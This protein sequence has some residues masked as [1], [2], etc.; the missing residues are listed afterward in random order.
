M[1][2]KTCKQC[3][4]ELSQGDRFCVRCGA[5]VM[6]PADKAEG[7]EATRRGS[8]KHFSTKT[9]I[10]SILVI[11]IATGGFWGWKSYGN[12]EARTQKQLELAVKYISENNY[13][14][15][16]LAYNEA[17]KIDPK[18]V[19]AYQGLARIYT[20]QEKYDEAQASYEQGLTAVNND[21]QKILRLGLAGMYIDQNKLAEA[22]KAFN[23][24]KNTNPNCLEAY[25]GMAMVYQKQGDNSKA[26]AVLRQ[27]VAQN[28]N[29]YQAYNTL[30]LFLQQNNK[31]AE[32]FNNLVKSLSLEINQ[33][34]AYVVLSDLYEGEWN[35][36][37]NQ[38][39]MLSDQQLGA[40]ME[41]YSYYVGEENVQAITIYQQKLGT[42]SNNQKVQV[43]AAIAMVK[44]DD[45]AGAEAIINKLGKDKL[46]EWLLSD[47][48]RY[49]LAVGDQGKAREYAIKALD[50]N[51]VNLDA[52]ALLQTLNNDDPNTKIYTAKALVYNW[53]PVK[54]VQQELLSGKQDIYAPPDEA[55]QN[56]SNQEKLTEPVTVPGQET[57]T[58]SPQPLLF[59]NLYE[60][61][62]AGIIP[63]E[64]SEASVIN[65]LGTP[66]QSKTVPDPEEEYKQLTYQGI[67]VD[68]DYHE[69]KIF[70][71][72]LTS[73]KYATARGIRVGDPKTKVLQAYGPDDYNDDQYFSNEYNKS[74][75][76]I[77][78]IYSGGVVSTIFIYGPISTDR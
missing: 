61:T 33:Q 49:Y 73:P 28:P 15:A 75:K 44:N 55:T 57:P 21:N 7:V 71:I 25:W 10:V 32:A 74:M 3:G 66:L 62:V 34:E 78:F 36:L 12:T 47:L 30:A 19:K 5:T 52:I 67:A 26:E 56:T 22:E 40:M 14:Q 4:Q 39:A 58:G 16:I 17:I 63:G 60:Y 6:E 77:W 13:E 42:Q 59:G 76:K 46:N 27:A 9:I 72:E 8:K 20:L 2:M 29:E 54:I 70:A 53:K 43:L 68:I 48:A 41:F 37:R 1:G 11:I 24:L 18:D 23:E 35:Q 69:P 45:K 50:A 65:K 31:D 64:D 38:A 51:R